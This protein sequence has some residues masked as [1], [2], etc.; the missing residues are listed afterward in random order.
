M[1]TLILIS[2][3]GCINTVNGDTAVYKGASGP[4]VLFK[5]CGQPSTIHAEISLGNDAESW[6]PLARFSTSTISGD[7]APLEIGSP[8]PEWRL[9][10]GDPTLSSGVEYTIWAWPDSEDDG[11][12]LQTRFTLDGVASLRNDQLISGTSS[13]ILNKSDFMAEELSC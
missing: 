11:S 9:D 13:A 4:A 10:A 12:F 3:T 1:T 5:W 2:A 7:G 8:A 6:R